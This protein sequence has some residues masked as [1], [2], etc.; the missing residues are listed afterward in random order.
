MR[1]PVQHHSAL[2]SAASLVVAGLLAAACKPADTP[3]TP[4][5]RPSLD[6]TVAASRLS[7]DDAG[8]RSRVRHV[9]LISVDGLHALDL[10]RFVAANPSSALAQ[11]ARRGTTF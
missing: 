6:A 8:N 7:D 5:A 10:S 4:Q 3:V 2:A 9:L 1:R 11:L